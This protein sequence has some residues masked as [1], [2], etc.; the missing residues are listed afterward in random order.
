MKKRIRIGDLDRNDVE[1]AVAYVEQA[2]AEHCL[3]GENVRI[4]AMLQDDPTALCKRL[5]GMYGKGDLVTPEGS[6][7]S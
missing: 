3:T 4:L 2:L 6:N 5:I 1:A 7:S